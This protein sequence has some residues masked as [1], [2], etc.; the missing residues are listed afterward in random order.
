MLNT[1]LNIN[2]LNPDLESKASEFKTLLDEVI[3]KGMS[4][5]VIPE[6][7]EQLE[8]HNYDFEHYLI[9]L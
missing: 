6:A 9:S 1:L 2:D 5:D 4:D 8:D 3:D 7:L